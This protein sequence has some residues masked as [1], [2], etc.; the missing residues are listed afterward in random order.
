[1]SQID[2]KELTE[3]R[4]SE[5][6]PNVV[7]LTPNDTL[8]VVIR[9]LEKGDMQLIV[10]FKGQRKVVA[11]ISQ[12]AVNISR[13]IRTVGTISYHKSAEDVYEVGDIS[14]YLSCV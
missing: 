2:I 10:E 9:T 13:L 14:T 6:F 11:N 12:S 4:T 1:M 7:I 5:V 3:R 8:P